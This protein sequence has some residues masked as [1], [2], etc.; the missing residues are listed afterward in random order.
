MA[1]AESGTANTDKSSTPLLAQL[2]AGNPEPEFQLIPQILGELRQ[3]AVHCRRIERR[4]H[5]LRPTALVSEAYARLVQLLQVRCRSRAHFFATVSQLMRQIQ[6]DYAR[7]H[8]AGKRG[9]AQRQVTLNHAMIQPQN[10]TNEIVALHEVL[11]Q[12]ALFDA[13]QARAVELHLRG[14]LSLADIALVLNFTERAAK[15]YW[16]V[17]RDWLK[18]ELSK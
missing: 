10:R 4:N 15:R 12:L 6:V 3:L 18:G 9:G 13:R 1:R 17:A 11:Q 16:S 8:Q 2:G 14:G 5:M 7:A